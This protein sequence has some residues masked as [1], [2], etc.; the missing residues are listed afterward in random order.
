M[1]EC[2][3]LE[4]TAPCCALLALITVAVYLPV[5]EASFVTFDD[6]YYVTENPDRA[7]GADVGG[8]AVGVHAGARRRTGIR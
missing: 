8:R 7:G 4:P 6:T 1:P 5:I 3:K 2:R